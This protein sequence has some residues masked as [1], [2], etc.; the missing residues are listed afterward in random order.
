MYIVYLAALVLDELLHGVDELIVDV[1]ELQEAEHNGQ[2]LRLSHLGTGVHI[3]KQCF[4]FGS[5][6]GKSEF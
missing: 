6:S 5:G 3:L 4:G 1:V 2:H